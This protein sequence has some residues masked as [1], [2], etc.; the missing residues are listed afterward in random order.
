MFK[1]QDIRV[2]DPF[3]VLENGVY[4]MYITSSLT[5]LSYYYSTNLEEWEQGDVVFEIPSDFWAYKDVWASEVHKYNGKFYLFVSLL[6]KN[7]LRGTQIAVSDTPN[8]KF[9][10]LINRAVTPINQSCIDGTLFVDNGTPY[11]IYSHD[12]PDNYDEQKQAYVGEIWVAELTKDLTQIK[13]EPKRLYTAD[14][15]PMAFNAPHYITWEGKDTK[16]YGSDAPF[17]QKLSNGTLFLTWS[18]FLKDTYVVTGVISK[19]GSIYG[20]WEHLK[21]P[22]FADN[23]G[24]AM[25]FIDKDGKKIMCLHAPE[26]LRN[27][28]AHLFIV[29]ED[30][31]ELKVEKEILFK[32]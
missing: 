30:G 5:T 29:K 16:R 24:H 1:R 10:P 20:P 26:Y 17:V 23:G 18:P 9:T 13:G 21:T 8:G 31:N 22:I 28:R 6:G 7:G 11:I 3:I 15:S 19:S 27:E 4:Y 14:E 2:R 12:W 25:F 32:D